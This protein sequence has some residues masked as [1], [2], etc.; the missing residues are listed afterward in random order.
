[1]DLV[2]AAHL[3]DLAVISGFEDC[4]GDDRDDK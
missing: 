4:C 1:M 3:V 2:Y